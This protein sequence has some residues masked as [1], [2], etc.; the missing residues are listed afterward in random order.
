MRLSCPIFPSL[1]IAVSIASPV[2]I[3][4]DT[5]PQANEVSHPANALE[6]TLLDDT[7]KPVPYWRVVNH[8]D[9][10]LGKPYLTNAHGKF[11]LRKPLPTLVDFIA[12]NDATAATRPAELTSTS[13]IVLTLSPSIPSN[14]R[15]SVTPTPESRIRNSSSDNATFLRHCR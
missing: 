12:T 7:G 13:P 8:A 2:C 11:V 10:N 5:N 4:A 15:L 1:F 9:S 3:L 6:C 14:V